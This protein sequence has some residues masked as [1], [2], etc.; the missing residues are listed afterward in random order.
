M[1]FYSQSN[2]HLIRLSGLLFRFRLQ[3]KVE[4]VSRRE[5]VKS[6]N[7]KHDIYWMFYRVSQLRNTDLKEASFC[8]RDEM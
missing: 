6:D 3:F 1:A 7:K 5:I 4:N 8:L 2:F